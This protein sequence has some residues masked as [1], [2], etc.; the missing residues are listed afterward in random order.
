[1]ATFTLT[2]LKLWTAITTFRHFSAPCSCYSG[3]TRL[4]ARLDGRVLV[5]GRHLSVVLLLMWIAV[6][7][8]LFI[9]LTVVVYMYTT[10]ICIRRPQY[11]D[12]NYITLQCRNGG[13]R[14]SYMISSSTFLSH[15]THHV[16]NILILYMLNKLYMCLC[17][18]LSDKGTVVL[19]P[20]SI[21]SWYSCKYC[22]VIYVF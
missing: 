16:W 14:N 8:I 19:K 2:R 20:G 11:T 10:R 17:I 7:A 1:M 22:K 12:T 21:L 9:Q 18:C 15:S 5:V 3:E 13:M 6:A 4:W